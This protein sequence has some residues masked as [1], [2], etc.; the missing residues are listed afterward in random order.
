[1]N[2]RR[3]T[4]RAWLVLADG[5]TF[6]GRG[7]GARGIATGEAVFTTA[8][9]GYEEVLT[10]PSYHGQVVT[11]TAPE[12]G[13]V[14]IN[15]EDAESVGLAPHLSGF[16]VRDLSPI[17]SNWRAEESIDAYLARHGIVAIT[18]VDTRRLTRHL[19]DN[20]SQN[21]AIGADD[22]EVLLAKARRA[23]D[24]NGLD[25]VQ[26]VTPKEPYSW[27]E[28][29]GEWSP[30]RVRPPTHHWSFWT[31]ESSATSFAAWS[32]RAVG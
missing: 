16:V 12:I 29:R 19:R 13:N 23:P 3:N 25:L 9:T 6:A 14:G 15:A 17:P 1:M 22:P 11:M 21:A 5:T 4:E 10:D 30:G 8:M 7:F 31:T 24:M 32:M 26:Y 20:G 28:G 18:D 2:E 27:T